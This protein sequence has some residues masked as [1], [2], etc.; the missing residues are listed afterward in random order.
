VETAFPSKIADY[1]AAGKPILVL[2][3]KYS[4]LVRYAREQ[5][6]AEIVEEFS[7]STLARTIRKIAV[8]PVDRETLAAKGAEVLLA[9]HDIGA[10]RRRFYR[11]LEQV[12]SAGTPK[13]PR[14]KVAS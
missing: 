9:N 7:S 6:F 5:G 2:G 13:T 10:Q 3:P 12:I 14:S 8:S 4:S 11:V 1:L